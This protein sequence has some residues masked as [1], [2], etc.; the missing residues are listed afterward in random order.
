MSLIF[1]LHFVGIDFFLG[2]LPPLWSRDGR[3]PFLGC[4]ICLLVHS[5][6]KSMTLFSRNSTKILRLQTNWTSVSHMFISDKNQRGGF[7]QH[8]R[9]ESQI[10]KLEERADFSC[11]SWDSGGGWIFDDKFWEQEDRYWVA[12]RIS[13]IWS[14]TQQGFR[15]LWVFISHPHPLAVKWSDP[16]RR[17]CEWLRLE[18]ESWEGKAT[19]IS[20]SV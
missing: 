4:S 13:N 14:Q 9:P 16:T 12:S 10:S 11:S 5:N 19:G 15:K 20:A 2:R 3:R 17:G 1:W 18:A 8:L 6:E 7:C